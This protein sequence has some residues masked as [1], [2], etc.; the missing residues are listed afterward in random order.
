MLPPT[1]IDEL[2]ILLNAFWWGHGSD[3]KKGVKWSTWE[4]LC[5]HKHDGGMGFRNLHMF[6][7]AML[8]KT[9]W[10]LH[11]NPQSL[12]GRILKARYFARTDI[13]DVG[14][15]NNPSYTWKGIHTALGL[16]RKGVRWK[17]GGG[18]SVRIWGAP[19]LDSDTGFTITTPV[20]PNF[21]D[22]VV[23]DLFI[24]GTRQWD[25]EL[26]DEV[27][28]DIDSA[29]I[30]RTSIA[31]TPVPDGKIWHF[32]RRGRYSVKSAYHLALRLIDDVQVY[33]DS[34]WKS[35]WRVNVPPK[36]RVFFWRLC[37]GWLVVKAK[38][39]S[40]YGGISSLCPLCS[41]ATESIWHLFIDCDFVRDCW[42]RID[43]WGKIDNLCYE[44]ESGSEL[45][46]RLLGVL[47]RTELERAMTML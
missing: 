40:W 25:V 37:K 32:E 22:I 1:L 9:V 21:E 12:I 28:N 30:L 13:L 7:V 16:V 39:A 33:G 6:N 44:V 35:I 42:A 4:A 34:I 8:G 38:I 43:L 19:W 15:V 45:F 17:V 36:I 27:F 31:P 18:T 46:L 41:M 11:K 5:K 2:H 3:P 20:V 10:R 26:I 23:H 14:L 24:P 29:K 47:D